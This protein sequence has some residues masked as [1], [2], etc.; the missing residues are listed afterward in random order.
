[1]YERFTDR[2]RKV[3][4]LANQEAHRFNHRF[5]GPEHILLGLVK[6]GC[7]VGAQALKTLG[8][9]LP[10][11][12][13]EIEKNVLSAPESS[14]PGQLPQSPRAKEVVEHAIDEARHL[15]HNYVGTEHMLLGV[16]RE[17]DGV[18]ARVL[19]N[20]GIKLEAVRESVLKLISQHENGTGPLC[21]GRLPHYARRLGAWLRTR[22][23]VRI[24][25]IGLTLTLAGGLAAMLCL[26]SDHTN[27]A[28]LVCGLAFVVVLLL[29]E[30]K[31]LIGARTRQR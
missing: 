18:A 16:L 21:Q 10:S 6:E 2:A 13:S 31:I 7:G 29:G 15:N 23:L 9:S 25:I 22:P 4:Q 17:G 1:M 19:A 11:L 20:L 30:L 12:R 14:V 3:M 27:A 5:I 8:I 24:F 28:A 26:G